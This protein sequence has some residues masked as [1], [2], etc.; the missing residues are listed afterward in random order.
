MALAAATELETA[1]RLRQAIGRLNRRLRVT[2]SGRA[3]G[4]APARV[5]ALLNVDRNGPI[6]LSDLAEDEGVNPTMLSRM[7]GDLVATGLL[8]RTNDTDDRRAAWVG[9]TPAGAELAARM[10]RERTEAV[11]VALAQ[12][13]PEH[14][15]LI[16]AALPALECL[17]KNLEAARP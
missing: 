2:D 8:E 1:Q 13:D 5:S 9:I 14:A 10:R 17:G 4:L 11:T 12:L 6:R 7:V 15:R 3:A 16:E